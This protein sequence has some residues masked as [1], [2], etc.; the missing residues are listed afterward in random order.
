MG[1]ITDKPHKSN[2]QQNVNKERANLYSDRRYQT[3][4]CRA[5]F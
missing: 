3:I 2:I 4:I 5:K 1:H